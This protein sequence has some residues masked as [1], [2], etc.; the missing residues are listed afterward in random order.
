MATDLL[1]EKHGAKEARKA[2]WFG[3]FTLI[4]S[5]IMMQMALVFQPQPGDQ[6]QESL[7]TIFGMLPQLAL[8]SLAAYFVSQLLDVRLFSYL[9]KKYPARNQLWI[10]MN[11]SATLSQLID[12]LVF[13]TIAFATVYTWDVWL[14][15]FIT[16]YLFKFVISVAATPVLYIARRFHH[17]EDE[18]DKSAA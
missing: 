13:C 15:I 6:T 18:E 12:S 9:K 16:T 17:P 8:A 14:Q 10:R 1:N 7:Q 2:V 3:F 11:G 4:T 5:T